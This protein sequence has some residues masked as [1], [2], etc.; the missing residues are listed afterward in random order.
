M[1]TGSNAQAMLSV[2]LQRAAAASTS[3]EAAQGV[4]NAWMNAVEA[5][6]VSM[7]R[8]GRRVCR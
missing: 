2:P 8:Q 4:L 5:S 1:Q 3:E 6:G 7:V